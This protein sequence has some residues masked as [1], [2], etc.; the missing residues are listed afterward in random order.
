[1]KSKYE[2]FLEDCRVKEKKIVEN[3]DNIGKELSKAVKKAEEILQ[4]SIDLTTKI[5]SLSWSETLKGLKI[6]I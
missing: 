6:K 5:V 1:M 3:I 2:H 4:D